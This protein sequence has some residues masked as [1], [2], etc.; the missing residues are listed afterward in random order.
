MSNLLHS[1]ES[2]LDSPCTSAEVPGNQRQQSPSE[3]NVDTDKVGA[4][5]D[6]DEITV[7]QAQKVAIRLQPIGSTPLLKPQ[8]LQVSRTQNIGAIT[9]FLMRRLRLKSAHVYVLSSFQPTPDESLGNLYDLFKTNG[10]LILSY[11]EQI[12]Y[13]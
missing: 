9:K 2:E 8:L 7:K 4:S 5:P 3:S 13:G 10:E 1:D 12:A 6:E 11:C